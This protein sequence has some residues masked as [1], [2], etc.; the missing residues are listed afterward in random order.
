MI[1]W[2][3][4]D[5]PQLQTAQKPMG[6]LCR[7]FKSTPLPEASLRGRDRLPAR[8]PRTRPKPTSVNVGSGPISPVAWQHIHFLGHYAFR[9]KQ[10]PIDLEAILESVKL[11]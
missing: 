4:S 5:S 7:L 8:G 9:D 2:I 10:H 11:L 3:A 1:R 6:L